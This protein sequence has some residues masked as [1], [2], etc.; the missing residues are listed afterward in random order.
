V[1]RVSGIDDI[2]KN[3]GYKLKGNYKRSESDF[4]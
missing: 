1:F 3:E 2:A 4:D